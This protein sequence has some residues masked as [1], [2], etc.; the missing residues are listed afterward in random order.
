L[1][2]LILLPFNKI[3]LKATFIIDHLISGLIKKTYYENIFK[4]MELNL[5]FLIN[6]LAHYTKGIEKIK[7]Y[8]IIH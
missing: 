3:L 1:Q 6:S 2:H 8:S 7:N 4:N 5:A